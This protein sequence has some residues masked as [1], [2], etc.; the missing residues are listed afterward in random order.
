MPSMIHLLSLLVLPLSGR[1][2][3][4]P[5][6]GHSLVVPL[7]THAIDNDNTDANAR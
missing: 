4:V 3:V 7:A 6:S 1:S 5:L 2:L